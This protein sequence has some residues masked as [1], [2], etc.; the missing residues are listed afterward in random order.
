M[1]DSE[2]W[3]SSLQA[4]LNELQ[5]RVSGVGGPSGS[6]SADGGLGIVSPGTARRLKQVRFARVF[7]ELNWRGK[8]GI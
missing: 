2:R 6:D 4:R 3:N 5:P 1:E 7:C 8:E